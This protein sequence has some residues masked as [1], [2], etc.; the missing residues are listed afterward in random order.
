MRINTTYL[1]NL[2]VPGITINHIQ[3]QWKTFF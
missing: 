3:N 1:N 2:K